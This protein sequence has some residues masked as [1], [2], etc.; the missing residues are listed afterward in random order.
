MIKVTALNKYFG[1][2]QALTNI[3]FEIRT[4]EI[5]GFLGQN[6]A[7]KT[8]LMRILTTFL[9]PTSGEVIVA[10]KIFL[11]NSVFVRGKIGYLP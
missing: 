5:V 4:G 11:I 1:H 8:T 9:R 6:G 3:T 10:V 7:G 2:F